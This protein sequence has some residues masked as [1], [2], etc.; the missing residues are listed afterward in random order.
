MLLCVCMRY[1]HCAGETVFT[2]AA[3]KSGQIQRA[4][5]TCKPGT[6]MVKPDKVFG[7]HLADA[8]TLRN[9]EEDDKGEDGNSVP[10][11]HRKIPEACAFIGRISALPGS[12]DA[13]YNRTEVP[14]SSEFLVEEKMQGFWKAGVEWA[15]GMMSETNPV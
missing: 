14:K 12:P 6:A 5:D 8:L 4:C 13:S 2:T 3:L 11:V 1:M 9:T 10:S 15:H 7:L